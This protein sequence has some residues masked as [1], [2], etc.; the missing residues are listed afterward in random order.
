MPL[1][2]LARA[3]KLKNRLK[4]RFAKVTADITAYN[5]QYV[6]PGKNG[7][8]GTVE[9][10][11]AA[12]A[13]RREKLRAALIAVKLAINNKNGPIQEAIYQLAE[14]KGEIDFLNKLPTQHGPEYYGTVLRER[15]AF[16][17]KSEVDECVK[18][19][20]AEIDALQEKIDQH[21]YGT[22]I[23]VGQDILE[24]AS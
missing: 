10:D 6:T 21:N 5:S 4:G 9:V 22:K 14:Y 12:L 23:D 17:R 16:K 15:R 20:E 1:I 19:L 2:S 7:G 13:A 18:K 24:L 11:V 8:E 3:L